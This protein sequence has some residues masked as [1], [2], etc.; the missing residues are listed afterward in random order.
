MKKKNTNIVSVIVL[1][2]VVA[3][4]VIAAFTTDAK[5][6]QKTFWALVPPIIAIVLAL[7]TKEEIGRAHV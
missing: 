2:V 1:I 7:V 3:V 6:V 5:S 4:L